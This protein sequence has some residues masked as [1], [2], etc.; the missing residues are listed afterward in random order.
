MSIRNIEIE[1]M[2]LLTDSLVVPQVAYCRNVVMNIRVHNYPCHAMFSIY[3]I[4]MGFRAIFLDFSS[5]I[6][7]VA[8][9]D[10]SIFRNQKFTKQ[11]LVKKKWLQ[12]NRMIC[13]RSSN[14][15]MKLR[16]QN[17]AGFPL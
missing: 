10:I 11:Y 6:H 14:D 13:I 5:T 15:S 3:S 16:V 17:Y 4:V 8:Q 1:K 9:G 2:L 12:G 7:I